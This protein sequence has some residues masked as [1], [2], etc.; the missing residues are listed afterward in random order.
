MAAIFTPGLKVS[1]HTIVVKDRRLPLKG[2]VLV[3]RG[4]GGSGRRHGGS[5]RACRARSTRSTWR[6]SWASTPG[7]SARSCARRPVTRFRQGEVV[8]ETAR[9]LRDVQVQRGSSRSPAP[10]RASR[11]SPARSS[12]R[13]HPVP[14]EIDAYIP[15]K[16]V[17]V[18]E[19]EGCVVQARRHPGAGHLRVGWRGQ[20][21]A[22]RGRHRTH[23][24]AR[25]RVSPEA[26]P[27]IKGKI[28]IGG[29]LRHPRC[30]VQRPSRTRGRGHRDRRLRLRRDQGTARLRGRGRDHGWGRPGAH[31]DCD[32]GIRANP[33]GARDLRV[34]HLTRP[35]SAAS[36]NGAT[37][38]RAG[39]IRPEVVVTFDDEAASADRY[40]E[41]ER[42]RHRDR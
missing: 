12:T 2:E 33:D 5:H 39:V 23:P 11:R 10:S 9:V 13:P 14:V 27:S 30:A 7:G 38:I 20:G 42:D 40:E 25:G 17:E 3:R 37:Q 28:V 18:I 6:T 24:S 41:P 16:V 15:G 1:E 22:R 32:R 31:L 34:A 8:A 21:R 26:K 36:I 19:G 35:A 29:R 4:P